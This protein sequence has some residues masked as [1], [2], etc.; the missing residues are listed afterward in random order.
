MQKKKNM[1]KNIY[2]TTINISNSIIDMQY[3]TRVLP[4]FSDT[5]YIGL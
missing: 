4:W 3:Y 2:S 1:K 5:Y